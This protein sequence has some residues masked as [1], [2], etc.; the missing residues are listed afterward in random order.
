MP[1]VFDKLLAAKWRDVEF[2]VTRMRVSIAHDLV[3]HKYWGVDGGRIEDTGLAPW[4]YTF[5]VPFVDGLTPGKSE[6]WG[7]LYPTQMRHLTAAFQL[8]SPGMLQH[9]EFGRIRCKA[10]KMDLDWD[11]A[12]RG[13]TDVEISFVETALLDVGIHGRSPIKE[14][15][16]ATGTLDAATVKRDLK[17]LFTARGIPLPPHLQ[18][19]AF[20]FGEAMQK[21][22]AIADYPALMNKRLAGQINAMKYHAE[23]LQRSVAPVRSARTWSVT[24]SIEQVKAAT[25]EMEQNVVADRR[26]I[27]FFTVPHDTTLAGV[28]RQIPEAKVGDLVK[29]NPDLLVRPEIVRGTVVRHYV[30]SRRAA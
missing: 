16:A 30:P 21:I 24:R 5:S 7:K 4:R 2:P 23:N 1:D 26:Q 20:S 8:R 27:G 13:G 14:A 29:L 9:P 22:K 11:A 25:H 17:A 19:G 18:D 6:R 12:R 10:D 28:A 15:D 3:E